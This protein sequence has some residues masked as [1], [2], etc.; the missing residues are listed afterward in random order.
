MYYQ[1]NGLVLRSRVSAEADKLVT[2][3]TQ[4]WGKITA[5]VPGA[6]KIKAKFSAASEPITESEFMIYAKHQSARP[7][8]TSAKMTESYMV[9]R[10]SWRNF[11]IA[12]YCAEICDQLT[13]FNAENPRK[14]ELLR[15]TWLLLGEAQNPWRIYTAFVLRFLK[16]SGYNFYEYLVGEGIKL[17]EHELKTIRSLTN[18]SGAELDRNF[19]LEA[20]SEERV[21]RYIDA[22]L[23]LYLPRPLSSKE[24]FRKVHKSLK[25][26]KVEEI[27]NLAV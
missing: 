12:N 23:S 19:E 3:Y 6:K 7:K 11:S 1:L 20:S 2:L 17:P 24:Y 8:V 9:L 25:A 22:Y 16:L 10:K 14:Y 26:C 15:R 18:L 5:I 13:P 4:E 27:A 21:R